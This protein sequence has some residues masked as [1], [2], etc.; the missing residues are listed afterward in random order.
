MS[1]TGNRRERLQVQLLTLNDVALRTLDRV[2]ASISLDYSVSDTLRTGGVM[3]VSLSGNVADVDWL[4]SRVAITYVDGAE[5]YPIGTFI[6]AM[7]SGQRARSGGLLSVELYDKLLVLFE[8]RTPTSYAVAAGAVVTDVVRELIAAAGEELV[9][10]VDSTETTSAVTT[11]DPGTSVLTIVNDLLASIDYRALYTDA[12]GVFVASPNIDYAD[13]PTAW[14]LDDGARTG[15][16][17]EEYGD[18]QDLFAVPNRWV[19]VSRA[20]GETPS[21]VSTRTNEDPASPY[22]YQAR[23]RWITRTTT[24]VEASSQEALDAI[25]QRNLT[26]ATTAIRI[27]E[28][29]HAW[30]P[31]TLEDMVIFEDTSRGVRSR[32]RVTAQRHDLSLGATTTS[33]LRE[34]EDL[35]TP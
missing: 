2:E 5:E 22:S 14:T 10:V 23:G 19:G 8:D 13:R 31:F 20:D 26:D 12:R 1:L 35:T 34:V 27:F 28:V 30:L 25:I 4:T 33:T 7:P 15:V 11:W 17:S 24:D 16:Y 32:C 6:P 29:S 18:A 9:S 3:K 21:F